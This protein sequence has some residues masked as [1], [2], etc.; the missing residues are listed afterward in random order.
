MNS[1][2]IFVSLAGHFNYGQSSTIPFLIPRFRINQD[3]SVSGSGQDE[4]GIYEISGSAEI[5]GTLKFE[6]NYT[7]IDDLHSVYFIG[8]VNEDCTISGQFSLFDYPEP[9]SISDG[10][11][12]LSQS[13][14]TLVK[15]TVFSPKSLSLSSF[16]AT[17]CPESPDDSV[18]LSQ[19]SS[20]ESPSREDR[21][22]QQAAVSLPSQPEPLLETWLP[23][24]VSPQ[25]M[26]GFGMT[27]RHLVV[28][29]KRDIEETNQQSRSFSIELVTHRGGLVLSDCCDTSQHKFEYELKSPKTTSIENTQKSLSIEK[30]SFR[31]KESNLIATNSKSLMDEVEIFQEAREELSSEPQHLGYSGTQNNHLNLQDIGKP[32]SSSKESSFVPVENTHNLSASTLVKNLTKNNQN[33]S[34]IN[35]VKF[36]LDGKIKPK[37]KTSSQ[38]RFSKNRAP[39]SMRFSKTISS[40]NRT[41]VE[42]LHT[43]QIEGTWRGLRNLKGVFS[44]NRPKIKEKDP[45]RPNESSTSN[46]HFLTKYSQAHRKKDL[47][48]FCR[49][50][51]QSCN[52]SP[53][54]P[55]SS[56]PERTPSLEEALSNIRCLLD[57]LSLP[58]RVPSFSASPS[59]TSQPS[60]HPLLTFLQ[61]HRQRP[62]FQRTLCLVLGSSLSLLRLCRPLRPRELIQCLQACQDSQA[63][64]TCLESFG[65]L[66]TRSLSQEMKADIRESFEHSEG[67]PCRTETVDTVLSVL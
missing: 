27:S 2:D 58:S 46:N 44:I 5:D 66:L 63:R 48:P 50:M 51:N 13:C 1:E 8:T 23:L 26:H 38:N 6:K 65:S 16:P 29:D 35:L 25:K 15:W 7:E 59:S 21:P 17:E 57:I 4:I 14:S 31:M 49:V 54:D 40:K 52:T 36:V 47:I 56:E 3:F 24:A 53:S 42:A 62:S 9:S 43:P 32:V 45:N 20:I 12:S 18:T 39:K 28:F 10:T 19:A 60:A 67:T 33:L 37:A 22:D 11:F 30:D 64:L 34:S 55:L 61:T 41:N